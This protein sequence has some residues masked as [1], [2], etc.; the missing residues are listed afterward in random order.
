MPESLRALKRRFYKTLDGFNTSA[1]ASSTLSARERLQALN[2]ELKL[3]P[4]QRATKRL[5][6]SPSSRS[7]DINRFARYAEHNKSGDSLLVRKVP[8]TPEEGEREGFAEKHVPVFAPQSQEAFF[9]RL[10]SF[11]SVSLWH[12]KPER[13]GELEWAKRGWS[14][15]GVNVVQCKRGCEAR[16]RVELDGGEDVGGG[17]EEREGQGYGD[18]VREAEEEAE[19]EDL[20]VEVLK[21]Q[22][23]EGHD[24]GCLWRGHVCYEGI[25]RLKLT[26][27]AVWQ[28]ELRE[29]FETLM[30]LR[31]TLEE[32]AVKPAE[33]MH[34]ELW[35]GQ[36][37]LTT[38]QLLDE[39]TGSVIP[40]PISTVDEGDEAPAASAALAHR[41]KALTIALHGWTATKTANNAL[42]ACP[43]CFQR[44]GLWMYSSQKS[45]SDQTPSSASNPA[46][47]TDP[48]DDSSSHDTEPTP[49]VDLNQLHRDYCPYTNPTTQNEPGDWNTWTG[50]EVLHQVLEN[51]VRQQQRRRKREAAEERRAFR[52]STR[53]PSTPGNDDDN[54]DDESDEEGVERDEQGF[55]IP[56]LPTPE[57]KAARDAKD[58][59]LQGRLRRIKKMFS[60]TRKPKDRA[61]ARSAERSG[62]PGNL[63]GLS[64]QGSVFSGVGSERQG[65]VVGSDRPRL[66]PV[67]P[68]GRMGES[69]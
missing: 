60:M 56:Q 5:R 15:A 38:E 3:P 24:E 23:V 48:N 52:H 41:V 14:C 61:A 63:G 39:L 31:D 62:L 22:I 44:V 12:P 67:T 6:P 43:A 28:R 34:K 10:R 9:E 69:G 45:S 36:E 40:A 68:S 37:N 2:Q 53:G 20:E 66:L 49:A 54:D 35:S 4:H 25:Y 27:A 21:R 18:R 29:R 30:E 1:D 11:A 17:V 32:F 51:H 64:R 7:L 8:E 33:R 19:E 55:V 47:T 65:S 50:I 57:Q 42:L 16:V 58:V 26:Q 46:T 59:E 13:V